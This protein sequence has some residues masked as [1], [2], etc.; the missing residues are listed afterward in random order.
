[1][2]AT[3]SNSN[4]MT[5]A[6]GLSAAA[7]FPRWVFGLSWAAQLAVAAV[8]AQTLFFKF[9]YAPE[10]QIIFGPR[11]GRPA[12]TLVGLVELVCVVLLL[13]PRTSFYGAALAFMTISGAIVTHL[14]SL[15]IQVVDPQSGE[16]D[17]GLLFALALAVF[18]GS[19]IV[20]ACRWRQVAWLRRMLG[21]AAG[22]R[23][24]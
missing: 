4:P 11:G 8:L 22:S 5:P 16:S 23:A 12:A 19:L 1:M 14:T 7:G 3:A 17:G 6:S 24:V 13:A 15:G 10:T 20:I 2:Q 18:A 21:A 9:T